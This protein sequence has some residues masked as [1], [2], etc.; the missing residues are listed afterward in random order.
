MIELQS[1]LN[2][3]EGKKWSILRLSYDT[4][5]IIPIASGEYDYNR[6]AFH[7][8]FF[9]DRNIN[10]FFHSVLQYFTASKDINLRNTLAQ[11]QSHQWLNINYW[12]ASI[13]IYHSFQCNNNHHSFER[14]K[15]NSN[16]GR[17]HA[18]WRR[19][20]NSTSNNLLTMSPIFFF[21]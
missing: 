1:S 16:V 21:P 10:S 20:I 13:V 4:Q 19:T 12:K 18:H 6:N 8:F 17:K 9:K 11:L 2:N 3:S 14:N 5:Y 7:T 15:M